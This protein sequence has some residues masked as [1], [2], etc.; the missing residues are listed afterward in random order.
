M[1]CDLRRAYLYSLRDRFRHSL[2]DAVS[3]R[4]SLI[5]LANRYHLDI[6]LRRLWE[7]MQS[8]QR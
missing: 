4:D 2:A 8:H 7:W 5:G 1:E 3:K 6:E